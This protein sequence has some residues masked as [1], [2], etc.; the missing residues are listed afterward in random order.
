MFVCVTIVLPRRKSLVGTTATCFLISK[1]GMC[2]GNRC[3]GKL[4][5]HF[6]SFEI[7]TRLGFLGTFVG[8]IGEPTTITT[9][10]RGQVRVSKLK[11]ALSFVAI[12]LINL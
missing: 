8:T 3:C 5:N 10:S 2:V 4:R 7:T 11:E 12:S 6:L 1:G 9:N